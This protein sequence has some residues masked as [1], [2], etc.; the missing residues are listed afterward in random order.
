MSI[1]A[2]D[3]RNTVKKLGERHPDRT[4]NCKYVKS[5]GKGCCIVGVA[6]IKSGLDP[7]VFLDDT[8]LNESVGVRTLFSDFAEELDL[9]SDLSD[10]EMSQLCDV[11]SDQDNGSTWGEAI[12]NIA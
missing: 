2:S 1:K 10:E 6:L 7:N 12:G 11:Q 5:D 9:V 3:V 4:R 8:E